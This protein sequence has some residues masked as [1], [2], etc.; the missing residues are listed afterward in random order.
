MRFRLLLLMLVVCAGAAFAANMPVTNPSFENDGGLLTNSCG[1]SCLYGYGTPPG[2]SQFGATGIMQPG[3]P[4]PDGLFNYV[5]N[6]QNIAL[7]DAGT[8]TNG[9]IWQVIGN[10]VPGTTYTLQVDFGWAFNSSYATP[11][12]WLQ[13]GNN[14]VAATGIDP[15]QGNWSTFTATYNAGIVDNGNPIE[16]VLGIYAGNEALFDNVCVMTGNSGCQGISPSPE[17]T[18][19]ILLGSGIGLLPLLGRRF[20]R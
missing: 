2:W 10:A 20:M 9:R 11:Y 13:I 7:V 4:Y 8:L 14:A 17:P 16:I 15:T 6:G 18:G 3:A 1:G 19:L 5:P 12:A